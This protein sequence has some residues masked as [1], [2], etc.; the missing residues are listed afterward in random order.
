MAF[1]NDFKKKVSDTTQ[2]AVKATK[3]WAE[4]NRF[5]SQIAEE[6]RKILSAESQIGKMYF[7]K[8]GVNCE[9]P[10]NEMCAAIAGANEQI[11]KLQIEIQRVKG[12][13][14]CPSCGN[15]VPITSAFCGNCGT[16]VATPVQETATAAE[17]LFCANCGAEL[18]NGAIFCGSCGHKQTQSE[19][20]Q[21]VQQ[22]IEN[23]NITEDAIPETTGN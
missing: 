6:Q 19:L 18:E 2:G 14:R 9:P 20:I 21:A 8:Y 12:L 22:E 13:K 16:A 4:I 3:D 5:N 7:E 23:V 15:D 1:F 10:F 17:T 11:E